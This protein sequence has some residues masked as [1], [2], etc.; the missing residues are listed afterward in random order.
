MTRRSVICLANSNKPGG[1]CFAGR[2]IKEVDGEP[3]IN[4]WVRPIG[5]AE[6][7]A[8]DWTNDVEF[9][10][11]VDDR[12]SGPKL[13]DVLSVDWADKKYMKVQPTHQTEENWPFKKSEPWRYD[14]PFQ[15]S[16]TNLERLV[17]MDAGKGLWS[18]R[19]E[20]TK[21]HDRVPEEN[22]TSTDGS[23]RFIRVEGVLI[24]KSVN[25]GGKS[26]TRAKFK[27]SGTEYSLSV[28]DPDHRSKDW[29]ASSTRQLDR[30]YLTI[31]L[32]DLF[33]GFAFKLVAGIIEL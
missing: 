19:V 2:L 20:P 22:L 3:D 30:C 4:D 7:G 12:A 21:F 25:D 6:S 27:Y 26:S 28:T 33:H 24:E 10:G 15:R 9:E 13:L 31:S 16:E 29:P 23:L 1:R 11:K 5:S 14:R 32:G 8:I 17:D 18:Q